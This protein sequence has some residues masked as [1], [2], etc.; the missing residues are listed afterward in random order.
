[1]YLMP[2]S[3][4]FTLRRFRQSRRFAL[5][6]VAWALAAWMIGFATHVHGPDDRASHTQGVAHVCTVCASLA[7]GVSPAA[8]SIGL[9]PA[10]SVQIDPARP[11][12]NLHVRPTVAYLSRAPPAA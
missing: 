9:P 5:A 1:M 11:S 12:E 2:V 7:S 10:F 4:L 3:S 6:V 8:V